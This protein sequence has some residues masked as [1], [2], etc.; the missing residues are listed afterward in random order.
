MFWGLCDGADW[1]ES[2]GLDA[3]EGGR[4]HTLKEDM[5]MKKTNN[6]KT[7]HEHLGEQL[8]FI[9]GFMLMHSCLQKMIQPVGKPPEVQD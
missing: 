4:D 8:A 5:G 9:C 6:N 7:A 2:Q 1:E 3:G